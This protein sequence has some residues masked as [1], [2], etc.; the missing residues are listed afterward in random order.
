MANT[1]TNP[2]TG[3]TGDHC[4][5]AARDAVAAGHDLADARG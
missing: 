5:R 4:L 1:Y 2:I 3:M